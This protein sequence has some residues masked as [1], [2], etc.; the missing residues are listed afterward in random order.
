MERRNQRYLVLALGLLLVALAAVLVKNRAFWFG[1][2]ES[3]DDAEQTSAAP[4][5]KPTP[6]ADNKVTQ[7]APV[8][9]PAP[10]PALK[11]KENRENKQSKKNQSIVAGKS[12]AQPTAAAAPVV[13]TRTQLPPLDVEVVSGDTHRTVH[14]G[15]NT[16]MVEIPKHSGSQSARSTTAFKWSPVTNVAELT[17]LPSDQPESLQASLEASY[18]ALARR[19]RVEGSVLLQASVDTD[20]GIRDVRVLSGNPILVS[21]AVDAA[22]QWRFA[23]HL[24]NGQPVATQAKIMV[25]FTIKVL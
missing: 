5:T 25:N 9:N 21:A 14:P 18:P 22:R 23:P 13:A 17:H 2:E 15:S 3:S 16:I 20:G 11:S 6:A 10:A 7:A 1:A 24:H 19:M 4:A 12:P 8:Q